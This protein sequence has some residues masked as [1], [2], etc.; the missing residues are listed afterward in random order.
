[1]AS[2]QAQTPPSA[3]SSPV[4]GAAPQPASAWAVTG[5]LVLAALIGPLLGYAVFE[6]SSQ[7]SAVIGDPF[8]AYASRLPSWGG[9]AAGILGVAL[10]VGFQWWVS[11]FQRPTLL[12]FFGGLVGGLAAVALAVVP[13]LAVVGAK[14]TCVANSGC[15]VQAGVP[16]M[17]GVVAAICFAL[18]FVLA[19]TGVT[20]TLALWLQRRRM[21]SA[22]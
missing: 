18:P 1:M 3:T 16:E 22:V 5:L 6:S 8:N 21:L 10:L 7:T 13:W 20:G 19:M 14:T 17:F 11:R 2:A 15:T 9:L 4:A 12:G